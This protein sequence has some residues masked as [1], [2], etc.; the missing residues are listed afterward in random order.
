MADK[1]K[2]GTIVLILVVVALVIVIALLAFGIL[3]KFFT[4]PVKYVDEIRAASEEFDV[5][6][7]LIA[8]IIMAESSYD[9][10]AV[11]YAGATGLM[12]IMP[13]TGKWI[14]DKLGIEYNDD[15]LTAPA[16]S[17]R[18]GTWYLRYLMDMFDGDVTNVLAAYNIGQGNVSKWLKDPSVSSDGKTLENIPSDGVKTYI[19]R[20]NRFY[21][22]YKG[23]YQ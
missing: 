4:Y 5:D 9:P 19:N 8:S 11:S 12:Q 22:F 16:D 18:M 15:M 14:C 10:K 1:R 7:P 3:Q 21:E 20:I 6:A 23:E 17:I 2:K 13:E